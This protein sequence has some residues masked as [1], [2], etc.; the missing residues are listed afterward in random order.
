MTGEIVL[1]AI[2]MGRS[3]GERRNRLKIVRVEWSVHSRKRRSTTERF[4]RKDEGEGEAMSQS[5]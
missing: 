4:S 1:E 3:S 2:S 5:V